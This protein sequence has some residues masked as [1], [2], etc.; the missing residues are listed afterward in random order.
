MEKKKFTD[1]ANESPSKTRVD[2][3]LFTVDWCPHCKK[4]APEWT[5]FSDKY[6]GKILNGYEVHCVQH[7]CTNT[8][9]T[10][11]A[12]MV[13]DYNIDSY[14]TVIL[15]KAGDRYDFDANVKSDNLAKFVESV[16]AQ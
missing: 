15:F 8:E 3:M 5:A 14:P 10:K 6:N 16:T 1:V 2:I 13:S 7:D 12:Q 11:V 4:A 9:D